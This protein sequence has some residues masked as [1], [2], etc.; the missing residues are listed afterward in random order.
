MEQLYLFFGAAGLIFVI[1]YIF[2][3]RKTLNLKNKKLPAEIEF[4]KGKYKIIFEPKNLKKALYLTTISNSV[5]LGTAVVIVSFFNNKFIQ[6]GL[7]FVII[8]PLLLLAYTSI[9]K[10]LAKG[11]KKDVQS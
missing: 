8:F 2:I 1:S 6:L 4:L 5:I 3:I 9:G 7:A 10:H 11:M